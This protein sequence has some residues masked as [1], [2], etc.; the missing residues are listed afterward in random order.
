M[1]L[2]ASG[3][4]S[5]KDWRGLSPA[6]ARVG[7]GYFFVADGMTLFWREGALAP[8]LPEHFDVRPQDGGAQGMTP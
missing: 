7:Y 6:R 2:K 8:C 4:L 3:V 5:Q 1:G